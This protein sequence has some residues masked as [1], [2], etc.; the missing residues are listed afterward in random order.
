MV[1]EECIVTVSK[2]LD[3]LTYHNQYFLWEILLNHLH[4]AKPWGK[5]LQPAKQWKLKY[6]EKV[7]RHEQL[8][9]VIYHGVFQKKSKRTAY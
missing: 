8:P 4:I 9:T 1:Q 2:D 3:R 5:L 7:R 6:P